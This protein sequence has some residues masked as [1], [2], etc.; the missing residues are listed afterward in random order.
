MPTTYAH[1]LFGKRIFRQLPEEMKEVIR[2]NGDLYRIGLHGP[3]ILFYHLAVS[4]IVNLGIAMHKDQARFFFERGMEL[5]RRRKNDPLLAYL[6][7]FGCHYLLDSTCHPYV[8]RMAEEGIISHTILEKEFDRQLML[9]T[10]KNPRRFY[11][12]SAIVPKKEYASVIHT[13]LPQ[14]STRHLQLCLLQQKFFTNA[15]VY[16]N[17]GRRVR[18]MKMLLMPAGKH[19]A[20][21]ALE[22]FMTGRPVKG[23]RI[24]VQELHQLFDR[25]VEEAPKELMELFELSKAPAALSKR[26][27]LTYNG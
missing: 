10:G 16:N 18:A 14:V 1:D 26:W 24:P 19:K 11:P 2:E 23:S 3:D 25:A 22:H 4:R 20:R 17:Q 27:D 9:E 8:N 15:M 13:V 7:G 12:S 21:E 6:L 5:V